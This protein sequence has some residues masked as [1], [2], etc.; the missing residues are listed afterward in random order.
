[1]YALVNTFHNDKIVSRHR[2]INNA[3]KANA[4][5]QRDCKR[6]N[7]ESSYMPTKIMRIVEG[8]LEPL[9]DVDHEYSIFC[10]G[11]NG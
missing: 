4:R 3:A 1:M 7:G 6:C 2:S 5:Y 10:T 9:N 11:W 8:S